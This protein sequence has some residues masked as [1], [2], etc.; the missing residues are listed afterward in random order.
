MLFKKRFLDGI[1]KGEVSLAF[2]RWRRPTVKA[3]GRL[4]TAVGELAIFAVDTVV[5]NDISTKDALRSGYPSRDELIHELA[6]GREGILY[7]I[8]FRLSGPDTREVLREQTALSEDEIAEIALR[9][10]RYDAL[11]ANGP[12]TLRVLRLIAEQPEV[13]AGELAKIIGSER[14]WLKLNVRKLKELGLTESLLHGYRLSPRGRSFLD[15]VASSRRPG[16]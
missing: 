3:G 6:T 14:E 11:A 2:R 13:R 8:E 10:K 5:E 7:R 9:V 15:R 16:N 12:W 4:R 1:A